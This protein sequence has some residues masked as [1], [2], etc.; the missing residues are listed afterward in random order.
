MAPTAEVVVD[1]AFTTL[2]VHGKVNTLC[3]L[4]KWRLD[5]ANSVNKGCMV[6]MRAMEMQ[7][8]L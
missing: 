5:Q 2:L 4:S 8:L 1:K 7:V 3:P 6:M